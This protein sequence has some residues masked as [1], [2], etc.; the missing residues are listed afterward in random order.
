MKKMLPILFL[1]LAL[2]LTVAGWILLPDQVVRQIGM[3]GH[4]T[5]TMSKP[6]ALILPAALAAIGGVWG[7]FAP[8]EEWKKSIAVA[9]IGVGIQILQ[10]IL[11]LFVR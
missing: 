10:I 4:V 7:L 6:L 1:V 2:V 8:P 3:D 5:A 9:A 11:N